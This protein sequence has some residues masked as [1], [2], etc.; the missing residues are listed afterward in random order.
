MHCHGN[1]DLESI[2][3]TASRGSLRAC[4]PLAAGGCCESGAGWDA[5]R[6]SLLSALADSSAICMRGLLPN[7]L[8]CS[9]PVLCCRL[10]AWQDRTEDTVCSPACACILAQ[11]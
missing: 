10:P 4:S 6:P 1:G 9:R 7:L 5:G 3:C 2:A 8:P 11:H